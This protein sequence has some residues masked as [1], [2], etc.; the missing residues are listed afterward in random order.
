[1][2]KLADRLWKGKDR[3]M[4]KINWD[5]YESKIT[6]VMI[7]V[8][9]LAAVLTVGFTTKT[10]VLAADENVVISEEKKDVPLGWQIEE[11]KSYY[12]DSAGNRVTGLQYIDNNMYLF[13]E[14][15]SMYTGW[16]TLA[17][18]RFYFDENGIMQTKECLIDGKLYQFLETGDF[19]TGWYER[20]GM[21]FYRDEYG[22]EKRGLVPINGDLYYISNNGMQIGEIKA[23]NTVYYTDMNGKILVGECTVDGKKMHFSETGEYLYGWR[24]V[25]GAYTYRDQTGV[26]LTGTQTIDGINYCFDE[27][28]KLYT[29]TVIGMY[30][31]DEQGVLTRLPVT[32]ETLDAALDE[33]LA[34]T[35]T[36][37]TAIGNYVK[38]TLRYKYLDKLA[39][40]EEMAVYAI[41][42]RR[43]SCYYYEA[44]CGLLLERAGYEVITIHGQGFVYADHYWSL[45]KTTRNG[46]EGWY[47]V[48]SLKGMYVKTD[49]E[50]VSKGFKWT[51][52]NYPATP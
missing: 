38:N 36:D 21:R 18:R 37:I 30:S 14:D 26:T 50:M 27:N 51:H 32:V 19:L 34:Q 15:G 29:N 23:N 33:I 47:H 25:D 46:I 41:N 22:Y 35:G 45:V 7:C 44:L 31:A 10:Q 16:I 24:L 49:A 11:D 4:K 20:D 8:M 48:D 43:C 1:M 3:I 2:K 52:E 12:L 6:Q 9:G 28:G 5:Q 40:R 17:D 39:T 13:M 42:N